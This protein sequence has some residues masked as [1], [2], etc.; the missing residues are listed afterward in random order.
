SQPR[1][2]PKSNS[3]WHTRFQQHQ[4]QESIARTTVQARD[5]RFSRDRQKASMSRLAQPTRPLRLVEKSTLGE[6][7]STNSS[8]SDLQAW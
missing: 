7:L 5:A 8:D 1:I 2:T 4:Q 6:T 3:S